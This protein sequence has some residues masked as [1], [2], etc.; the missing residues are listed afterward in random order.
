MSDIINKY[1]SENYS[2]FN[3]EIYKALNRDLNL[4]NKLDYEAHFLLYGL[5]EDR[6]WK[7]T[8]ILPDFNWQTYKKLNPQLGTIGINTQK[9]YELHYLLQGIHKKLPYNYTYNSQNQ[10]ADNVYHQLDNTYNLH[11]NKNILIIIPGFGEPFF[12]LKVKILEKNIEILSKYT[13]N[14]TLTHIRILIFL[15]SR[16]KFNYI[17]NY[18]KN[19]PIH[20]T[21]I[22]KQ[23][24]IGE[25]IHKHIDNKLVSPFEYIL[26]ILDDIELNVNFDLGEII[27]IYTS[28][29]I[30]ILGFPLTHDSPTP[31]EFMKVKNEYI[32][33]NTHLLRVNFIEFFCYF[34]NIS[35]FLKYKKI[36]T[37]FTYWLWG[38][39]LILHPIGFK[40]Y[41]LEHLP[42]RH[43]LKNTNYNR[44]LPDPNI[45]L[46]DIKSRYPCI[47]EKKVLSAHKLTMN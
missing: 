39:D 15:Y 34:M 26:F 29:N 42:I 30:D 33:E 40:I 21:I 47:T 12:D 32:K 27:K 25:F 35:N 1:L 18:L 22:P 20:V 41:R 31:H 16:E 37:D 24:I 2:S 9:D 11:T 38:L 17:T 3:W 28:F 4:P 19:S 5:D 36:F 7:I 43:Y 10:I 14:N 46:N 6:K 44:N 13:H 45:E 8:D 23:G